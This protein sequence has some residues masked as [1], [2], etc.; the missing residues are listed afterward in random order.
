VVKFVFASE[1]P[2]DTFFT[3]RSSGMKKTVVKSS[4][5][6]ITNFGNVGKTLFI[7]LHAII[8]QAK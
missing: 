7:L 6:R 3:G 1:F 2:I 5:C 8:S 4:V